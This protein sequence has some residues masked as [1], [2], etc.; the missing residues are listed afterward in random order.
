MDK[1]K[2]NRRKISPSKRK[3]V[4]NLY[5][6]RCAYCGQEIIYDDMHVDHFVARTGKNN[7]IL[8][9]YKPSCE[10]CN[11]EKNNLS[12]EEFRQHIEKRY[13]NLKKK[14]IY[15]SALLY[16]FIEETFKN[17]PIIFYFEKEN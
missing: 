5:G 14:N 8:S 4:Y 16:G 7:D 13:E 11:Q 12:I 6:G 2:G 15:K 17:E 10:V 3:E 9:N 1:S